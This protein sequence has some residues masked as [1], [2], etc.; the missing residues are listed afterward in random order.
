MTA[1][2]EPA[3]LRL[4]QLDR[5]ALLAAPGLAYLGLIY[6]LPLALLLLDSLRD[7]DGAF[8]LA[9]YAAFF[10]DPFNMSVLWRTL[11]IAALTTLLALLIAWPTAFA[12]ARAQGLAQTLILAAMVLPLSVGVIVKAFAWS[13]LFR[14]QGPINQMLTGLGIVEQPLRLLFTETAL[15]IG[16]ANVFLPFA[17]LPI[18]A[19]IRQIDPALSAAAASLGATPWFRFTRVVAPLTAPGVVAG[20]AFVFS[21]AVSMYVTP[22]LIVGER[23]QVL[24]MLIARSFLFLRDEQFGATVSAILLMIAVAVVMGSSWL[25]ARMSGGRA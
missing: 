23:Q 14:T 3:P 2:A 17:V 6:A 22:S 21:L 5:F 24:S 15:I 10:A 16:A 11:R 4:P 13:I 18:Y 8:T 7:A 25:V 1:R 9:S 12:L 20:G 19:V